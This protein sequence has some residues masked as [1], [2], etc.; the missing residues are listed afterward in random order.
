MKSS[1][2]IYG[3]G[4]LAQIL[5]SA[6]TLIQWIQ[7]EK[8]KKSV[9]PAIY[10]Q[11]SIIASITMFFYGWLRSDFAILLG[12]SITY[13]IYIY[14]LKLQ[15][16]WRELPRIFRWMSY[17]IPVFIITY[18]LIYFDENWI[19]LFQNKNIPLALLIWGSTGQIIFTFRFVYQW[20]YSYKIQQSVLSRGFWLISLTGSLMIIGY[21]VYRLDPVLFIGNL[22]GASIYA[23]NIW[24]SKKVKSTG[25]SL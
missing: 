23:R 9:S 25:S 17:A 1:I 3:L 6:R 7:S 10:W 11:L 24:L 4:F 22:F 18:S 16:K 2:W 19:R 14:N 12:Q 21:A 20:L 13:Y 8:A 15:D 5:F